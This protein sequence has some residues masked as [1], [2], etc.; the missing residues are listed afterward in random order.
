MA[1]DPV[2]TRKPLHFIASALKDLRAMPEAVQDDFGAALL[3]AQYGDVPPGSRPFGE[4]LP[5]EIL[6]LAE[7]NDGETYRV[8]YTVAFAKAVYVL[9]VFQKKSKRGIS[10]P[11]PD[12]DRVRAR[13]A[14]A[15]RHY[16]EHYLNRTG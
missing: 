7:D 2:A 16:Q 10:T 15:E 14:A 13:F 5:R 8:A 12:K 1:P 3:D 4:G 11:N 6:K 9:D